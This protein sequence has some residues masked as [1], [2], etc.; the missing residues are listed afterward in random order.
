MG[1][2][3]DDNAVPGQHWVREKLAHEHAVTDIFYF[4]LYAA[5]L[6]EPDGI[7]NQTAQFHTLLRGDTCGE[8]C[9]SNTT[10]LRYRDQ[11]LSGK[12]CLENVLR[13][14]CASNVQVSDTQL[15]VVQV[16]RATLVRTSS[17]S[18]TRFAEKNR[19]IVF[20][21]FADEG[22]APCQHV[23]SV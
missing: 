3:K 15:A 11:A 21:D 7:S 12:P 17:F 14:F 16:P 4:G 19:N 2:V 6:V 1:L 20:A 9:S 18:G 13:D 8:S 10:G 5:G 23:S 22:V